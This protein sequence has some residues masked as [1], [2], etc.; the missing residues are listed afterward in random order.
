MLD[1]CGSSLA[2][3]LKMTV[4]LSD[5]NDWSKMNN[6]YKNYFPS[7]PP[8]RTTFQSDLGAKVEMDA[9]AHV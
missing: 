8:A 2:K 6:I 7:E 1:E 9:I 5:S 3:V 4:I